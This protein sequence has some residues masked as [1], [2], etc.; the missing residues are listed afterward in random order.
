MALHYRAIC[1]EYGVQMQEKKN[2][3]IS[4]SLTSYSALIFLRLDMV[5]AGEKSSHDLFREYHVKDPP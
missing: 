2:Q 4:S 5:S 1:T 3:I